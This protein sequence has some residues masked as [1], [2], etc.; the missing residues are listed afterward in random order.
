MPN[1]CFITRCDQR[2]IKILVPHYIL[3]TI[4]I[5]HTEEITCVI[6]VN[7]A[8]WTICQDSTSDFIFRDGNRWQAF[9][10]IIPILLCSRGKIKCIS[11]VISHKD[12]ARHETP[13]FI[14]VFHYFWNLRFIFWNMN[15]ERS[16]KCI[17]KGHSQH[18]IS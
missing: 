10:L 16:G 7:S 1:V 18:S 8:I 17:F 15:K 11:F 13:V 12:K 5:E 9:Y 2:M 14:C 3:C 4:S 6:K